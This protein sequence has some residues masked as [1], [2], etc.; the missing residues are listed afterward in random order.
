MQTVYQMTLSEDG[1]AYPH[2]EHWHV[3]GVGHEGNSL[4]CSGEYFDEDGQLDAEGYA[5]CVSKN[6]PRGGITC[7]AC[8]EA[9]RSIKAIKL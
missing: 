7:P 3:G 4:L 9:I 2:G 8:L 5:K 6:V 1:D